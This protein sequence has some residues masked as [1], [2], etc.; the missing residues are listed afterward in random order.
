MFS[1]IYRCSKIPPVTDAQIRV[2]WPIRSEAGPLIAP[3]YT[4]EVVSEAEA[5]IVSVERSANDYHCYAA[6]L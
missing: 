6:V 1:C 5:E 2:Y 3:R 4:V